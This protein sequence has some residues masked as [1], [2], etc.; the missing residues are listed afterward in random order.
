[1]NIDD[2]EGG[3]DAGDSIENETKLNEVKKVPLGRPRKRRKVIHIMD[4]IK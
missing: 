2:V 3:S 1:M 4:T